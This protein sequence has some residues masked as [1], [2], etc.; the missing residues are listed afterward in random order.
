MLGF[1]SSYFITFFP[2]VSILNSFTSVIFIFLSLY[3]L[4]LTILFYPTDL[5]RTCLYIFLEIIYLSFLSSNIFTLLCVWSIIILQIQ[6]AF[7]TVHPS[8]ILSRFLWDKKPFTCSIEL[9]WSLRYRWTAVYPN[10]F[11]LVTGLPM[12]RTAVTW[13]AYYPV[14]FGTMVH[15]FL[16]T[17]TMLILI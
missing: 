9:I 7:G 6:I 12:K 8:G 16:C 3:I 4:F 10:S 15:N 13:T 5:F 11:Y 2:F 14:T 1:F 17:C